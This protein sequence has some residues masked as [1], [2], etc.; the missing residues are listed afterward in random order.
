MRTR[1]PART[2]K[3]LSLSS[4]TT[5]LPVLP[6]APATNTCIPQWYQC[7]S[8][9]TPCMCSSSVVV[10]H[11]EHE[12]MCFSRSKELHSGLRILTVLM[13]AAAA[14]LKLALLKSRAAVRVA[15]E[16][17]TF[18]LPRS[19]DPGATCIGHTSRLII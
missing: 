13:S 15:V 6:D 1:T 3:P 12:T 10:L 9:R 8:I 17:K 16:R 11:G 2:A 19:D 7:L 18:R 5:F 4:L 14:G